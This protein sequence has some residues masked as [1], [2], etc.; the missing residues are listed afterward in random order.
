MT[1]THVKGVLDMTFLDIRDEAKFKE[2]MTMRFPRPS[3]PSKT[4]SNAADQPASP[5]R[6]KK[7]TI[8][9][10]R[11]ANNSIDKVDVIVASISQ[12]PDVDPQKILWMDLSFNNISSIPD[13]FFS[14][15]PNLKTIQL[16][17]NNI[18]K[19]SEIKKFSKLSNLTSITLFGNPVEEHKH[20]RNFTLYCNP[21]LTSFDMSPVIK[22]ERLR[23]SVLFSSF[24]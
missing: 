8:T 15:F 5:K 18:S 1:S 20:Y 23:V 14:L 17:A 10:I 11:L 21:L 19:V 6:T 12:N 4:A 22:S 7:E 13:D 16:H 9:A 24:V 3:S 2:G